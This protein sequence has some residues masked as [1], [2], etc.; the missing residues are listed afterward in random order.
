MAAQEKILIFIHHIFIL[1][2]TKIGIEGW[3]GWFVVFNAKYNNPMKFALVCVYRTLP[4]LNSYF[5]MCFY[6]CDLCSKR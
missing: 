1:R 6:M 4:Y 3:F 5:I 2:E